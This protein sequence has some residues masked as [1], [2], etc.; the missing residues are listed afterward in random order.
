M[1]TD[2]NRK[3]V[4]FYVDTCKDS[5]WSLN[6]AKSRMKM[7]C[8][9]VY[10]AFECIQELINV[11][12]YYM[13]SASAAVLETTY[14]IIKESFS[15]PRNLVSFCQASKCEITFWIKCFLDF[16]LVYS[17]EIRSSSGMIKISFF[18]G[19][20]IVLFLF[21]FGSLYFV[22]Q[23]FSCLLIL[24]RAYSRLTFNQNR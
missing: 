12:E 2:G 17:K 6:L 8:F 9:W 14:A 1:L 13:W 18:D 20:K 4:T 7:F 3:K 19:Q 5:V 21:C 24:E 11:C 16:L 23:I 10:T 22:Q 15:N